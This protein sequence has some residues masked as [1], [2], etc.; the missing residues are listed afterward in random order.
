MNETELG[1]TLGRI[2]AKLD[3]LHEQIQKQADAHDLLEP[4]V[5]SLETKSARTVGYA[6]GA[7]GVLMALWEVG[8]HVFFGRS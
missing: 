5:R 1:R 2:E 8:K 6:A 4:R 3:S 7:S